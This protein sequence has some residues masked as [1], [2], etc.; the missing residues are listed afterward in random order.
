MGVRSTKN[1]KSEKGVETGG[2]HALEKQAVTGCASG[3]GQDSSA[4]EGRV[5]K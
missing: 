4:A 1:S 3:R 5:R 2:S